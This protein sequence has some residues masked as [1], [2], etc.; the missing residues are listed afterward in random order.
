MTS[1]KRMNIFIVKTNCQIVLS[2]RNT[3]KKETLF[4][5]S[6][7][8]HMPRYLEEA[9]SSLRRQG[10]VFNINKIIPQSV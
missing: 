10:S 7:S 8:L 2:E 4:S 3:L 5:S 6:H 9:S 1:S